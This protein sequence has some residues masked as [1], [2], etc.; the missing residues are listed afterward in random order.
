MKLVPEKSRM[1]MYM[2]LCICLFEETIG[3]SFLIETA[4]HKMHGLKNQKTTIETVLETCLDKLKAVTDEIARNQF[5]KNKTYGS[6][7]QWEADFLEVKADVHRLL[8]QIVGGT[9]SAGPQLGEIMGVIDDFVYTKVTPLLDK[10][11][12]GDMLRLKDELDALQ[13]D[14]VR[15]VSAKQA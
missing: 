2:V 11:S 5:P 15:A 1:K 7:Y 12:P 4:E 14:I 13:N 6:D 3:K 10:I 9:K 8:D